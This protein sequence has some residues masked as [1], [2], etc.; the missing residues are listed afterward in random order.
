MKDSDKQLRLNELLLLA[1]ES[2]IEQSQIDELNDLIIRN[3]DVV[4]DYLE[5]MNLY[6]ALSPYGDVG[7]IGE[8][9]SRSETQTYDRFLHSLAQEEIT[10]PNIK[11]EPLK[12]EPQRKLIQKVEREKIVYKMSRSSLL[13]LVVSLAACLFIV[14]FLRISP[15]AAIEVA[16]VTDSMG[17]VFASDQKYSIGSRLSNRKESIWLQQ[18]IIKIEFDYGAEVVIEAPAAFTLNTAD[19]MTLHSGRLFAHVPGRSKGFKIETPTATVIDLGTDF[20]VKA[21]FDGTSDVHLLKGKASLIPGA[22]GKSI[23]NSQLLTVNQARR[24]ALSGQ[25][26]DIPVCPKEFVRDINSQTGLIWRGQTQ[27][28]LADMVCGGNGFGTGNF[29]MVIDPTSGNTLKYVERGGGTRV[30]TSLYSRVE[31]LKYI[32]G[33]FVPDGGKG[34]I[35]VS[36]EGTL[37]MDCPTTSGRVR[38]DITVLSN[39]YNSEG[40]TLSI[41][42]MAFGYPDRP[43]ISMHA[44]IGITFDL[45][46]IR[47]DLGRMEITYFEA[48]CA[49][50]SYTK[51]GM[52]QAENAAGKADFWILIDGQVR[53]SLLGVHGEFSEKVRIPIAPAE[54]FLTILTTDHMES[55]E[56]DPIG[57]DRCFLGDPVLE[58]MGKE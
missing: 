27:V 14:L 47:K 37:F 44:N 11:L 5:F 51:T 28:D 12:R 54:R 49:V 29:A 17:T 23:G 16:T 58:I 56:K 36:S 48:L 18:G 26:E 15:N 42:D 40:G 30:A 2:D 22:K 52:P 19:D 43:A 35:V 46:A 21:D 45:D 8:S 33:V 3:H 31:S 1:L 41:G 55:T 34:P 4:N 50:T 24:V 32:D 39:V 13:T 9:G 25:V 7:R 20:A 38:K 57:W 6:S 53:K 10:A